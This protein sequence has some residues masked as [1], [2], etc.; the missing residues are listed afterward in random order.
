MIYFISD[1]AIPPAK[2]IIFWPTLRHNIPT[3]KIKL[4][5]AFDA[6]V[7]RL[8][9]RHCVFFRNVPDFH[10]AYATFP[11]EPKPK[12]ECVEFYSRFPLSHAAL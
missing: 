7:G 10:E 11:G 9:A 2:A 12:G 4:F 6:G 3:F 8:A 5:T 1:P